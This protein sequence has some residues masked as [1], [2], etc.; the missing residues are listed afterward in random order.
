MTTVEL[1]KR[2]ETKYFI[3]YIC[4]DLGCTYWQLVRTRDAAILSAMKDE[5]ML[6]AEC[7]KRGIHCQDV[8]IW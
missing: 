8:T 4:E 7:F 5:D 1:A 2:T 3:E 6:Y